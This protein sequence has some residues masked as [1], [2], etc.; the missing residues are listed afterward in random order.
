MF[1]KALTLMMIV[2]GVGAAGLLNPGPVDATGHSA[3]RSFSATTVTGGGQLEV[4]VETAGLGS[5]GQVTETLPGGFSYVSSTLP[6]TAVKTDGQDVAFTLFG[7]DSITYTVSV[8][9]EA[10]AHTF[11][12]V[13]LD[14]EKDS[15]EVG[16]D[17]DVMVEAAPLEGLRAS[18]SFSAATVPAGGGL[19]VTITAAEYGEFGQV[20]E[21]LPAGFAYVS[22]SLPEDPRILGRMLKFALLD[23]ESFTYTLTASRTLASHEFSGVVKDENLMEAAVGG[24][25]AVTVEAA[26]VS[27]S[28]ARSF[29]DSR[30]D[31]GGQLVVTIDLEGLGGFGR[32]METLPE[33]FGYV[34]SSL[35]AEQ[36]ASA[37]SEITF[38]I[39]NEESFTYTVTASG[40]RDDYTFSGVV[41]N[42]DRMTAA[43]GGDTTIAVGAPV[44]VPGAVVV[45]PD[46]AAVA[47]SADGSAILAIPAG[48][49]EELYQVRVETG[50]ES[51]QDEPPALCATITAF[52]AEGA[53][54]DGFVLD[55]A[56]VLSLRLTAEQ[57]TELGGPEIFTQ[58]HEDGGVM[59]LM[60]SGSGAEWTE[61]AAEFVLGEDGSAIFT[62]SITGF[63]QFSVTIDR[64]LLPA[65]GGVAAPGWLL[66]ALVLAGGAM[67]PAG[68]LLLRGG[69]RRRARA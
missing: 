43:V 55:A 26:A 34:S 9:N 31:L 1:K 50:M 22:T 15:R 60:R 53:E 58:L 7:V 51:C 28:A 2:A 40:V 6:D 57:V 35:A 49:S 10:G 8:P 65:T 4:T 38:T 11:N 52:D 19:V 69:A 66:L 12:G 63:G 68:V 24:D 37:D 61:L 62:A 21:T 44:P 23:E 56:A 47:D 64:T 18:R 45:E 67:I 25:S 14:S 54:I 17:S 13:V 3:T 5:F 42:D 32:V 27:H 59:V 41:T 30:V 46:A 33:G 16:G 20:V 39:L 36:V 29:S 48:S